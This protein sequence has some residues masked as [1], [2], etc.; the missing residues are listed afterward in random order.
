MI[1]VENLT[2]TDAGANAPVVK[3]MSVT[4]EPGVMFRFQGSCGARKSTTQK[5]LFRGLQGFK[6]SG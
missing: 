5:I 6:G 2:F 3:K 1:R 4:I